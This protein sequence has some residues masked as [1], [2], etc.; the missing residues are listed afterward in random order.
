MRI[1]DWSSDVCSSDLR[2]SE[3][4]LVHVAHPIDLF[5]QDL[6]A[7]LL[8]LLQPLLN[9]R[10]KRIHE[11]EIQCAS[12]L[13]QHD[14]IEM[15]VRLFGGMDDVFITPFRAEVVDTDA[16]GLVATIQVLQGVD[17]FGACRY[18]LFRRPC[19]LTIEENMS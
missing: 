1:S 4:D 18:L 19:I 3:R 15:L 16:A 12:R 6:E 11:M 5:D 14:R 17:H 13:R 9:L 8:G 7:N 2:S 10:Q